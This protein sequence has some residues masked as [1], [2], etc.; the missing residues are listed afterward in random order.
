MSVGRVSLRLGDWT[1]A[2]RR[3]VEAGAIT[4]ILTCPP[5]WVDDGAKMMLA[6]SW[7]AL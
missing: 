6:S 2:H 5:S 4:V 7:A 1:Q 3:V